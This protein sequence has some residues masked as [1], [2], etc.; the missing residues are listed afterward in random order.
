MY[1]KQGIYWHNQ[2]YQSDDR[3]N[4]LKQQDLTMGTFVLAQTRKLHEVA[5]LRR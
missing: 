3:G 2:Q 4:Q 1:C 5:I